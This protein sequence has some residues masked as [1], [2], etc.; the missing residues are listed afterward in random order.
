MQVPSPSLPLNVTEQSR[1]D[2]KPRYKPSRCAT[3][4]PLPLTSS[5][6]GFTVFEAG[7]QW[8]T[9][10]SNTKARENIWHP[11]HKW[12]HSSRGN[13]V[14]IWDFTT[15][16]ML[17]VTV[18]CTLSWPVSLWYFAHGSCVQMVLSL[19]LGS[20][21]TPGRISW[22]ASSVFF[23]GI[24]RSFSHG[25]EWGTVPRERHAE[26]YGLNGRYLCA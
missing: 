6:K 8:E 4:Y 5:V 13:H 18:L 16:A 11:T 21:Y 17:Y 3:S 14:S 25:F 2:G 23:S 7:H 9:T 12:P 19:E 10:Y 26:V 24:Y 15:E 22:E 1:W 20:P